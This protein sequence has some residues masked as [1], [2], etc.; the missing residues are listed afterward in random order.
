MHNFKSNLIF[1]IV[2]FVVLTIILFLVDAVSGADGEI[3]Q[4]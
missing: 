2:L 1:A 4:A 3:Q